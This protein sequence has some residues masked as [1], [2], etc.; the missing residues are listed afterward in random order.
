M[1]IRT[2]LVLGLL[3]AL[4]AA[5]CGGG[6]DGGDKVATA[7]G[8]TP[9]ASASAS[10]GGPDDRDA[11]FAYSKCMRENG[12]PDFP[13][14][15]VGDNGEFRMG[16][17]EGV[18]KAKV[19]A[20]QKVCKKHL[21]NGGEPPKADPERQEQLRKY[22]KCMRENGVPKFP[23]PKDGGLQIDGNEVGDPESPTFKAAEEK[24]RSIMPEPPGGGKRSVDRKEG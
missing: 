16:L 18:D 5:G 7:G 3:L 4:S 12:L 19:D 13:D 10:P 9:E 8:K 11:I 23:D 1:R 20:A 22:A 17:P 15:E 6:G 14:P 21:P 24:C 2:S